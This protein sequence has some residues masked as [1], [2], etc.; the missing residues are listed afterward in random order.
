MY[1]YESQKVSAAM[2][3]INRSAGVA[4]EVNLRNP[5]DAR[6]ETCKQGILTGFET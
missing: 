4:P 3:A 6:D 1:K 2:L 5:L